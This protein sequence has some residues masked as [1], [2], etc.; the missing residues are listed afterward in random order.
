MRTSAEQFRIGVRPSDTPG[1][2]TEGR[3]RGLGDV[4]DVIVVKF[5]GVNGL[6]EILQ[7]REEEEGKEGKAE[8]GRRA[9][10][11]PRIMATPACLDAAMDLLPHIGDFLAT[12]S[13][14]KGYRIHN[15]RFQGDTTGQFVVCIP[16]TDEQIEKVPFADG[17]PAEL[18]PCA[19]ITCR[20]SGA[21]FFDR[22]PL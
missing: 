20:A 22:I 11:L 15:L 7:G 13:V 21:V 12:A 8:E 6:E 4:D 18:R 16:G 5:L 1:M 3:V 2:G 9:I 17:A 19:A 10:C 14:G